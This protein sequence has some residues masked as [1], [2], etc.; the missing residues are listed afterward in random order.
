LRAVTEGTEH[1]NR[2]ELLLARLK[3]QEN[4]SEQ[5]RLSTLIVFVDSTYIYK[6]NTNFFKSIFHLSLPEV[7]KSITVKFYFDVG[8]AV[9]GGK[10]KICKFYNVSK[11]ITWETTVPD[12]PGSIQQDSSDQGENKTCYVEVQIELN[13]GW[14]W[15]GVHKPISWTMKGR[16][17]QD[18]FDLK[19]KKN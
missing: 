9:S 11:T 4:K 8:E 6:D 7:V 1:H 10:Y 17:R 3:E 12:G 5:K 16:N 15:D 2:I 19:L 14:A 18:Q 13:F